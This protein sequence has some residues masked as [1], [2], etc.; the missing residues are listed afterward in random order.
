MPVLTIPDNR[1]WLDRARDDGTLRNHITSLSDDEANAFPYLWEAWARPNQLIPAGMG[2]RFRVWL[3]RAGRG[4]GKTRSGAEAVRRMVDSGQARRIALVAPTVA[5]VRDV[6]IEGESGLLSVFPPHQRPVFQP[7]LRRVTFHNGATATTFSA[8][9]PDRLRGPQHDYAWVE[10]PASMVNGP[11][12][13]S[14]LMLGL[15]LG[16]APWVTV[17]GTPKPL[18]WLRELADR[19]DTIETTG[20]TYDNVRY[21][22]PT[23]IE[24]VLGRFEG[25][26]LGRQELH[27]EWLEGVEGALWVAQVIDRGRIPH[28]DREHPWSTINEWRTHNGLEPV[29][30]RRMWRTVVAVDPPGETAECGIV[31]ATA[32]TK[33]RAGRDPVVILADC[34]VSGRPEQWGAAVV[35]AYRTWG[36]QSVVVEANQG[37]DMTRST[38]HAVSTDVPVRKIH[39]RDSKQARAEPVSAL[40]ERGLV[41]HVGYHPMLESQMLSWVPDESRSPDRLDAMVH[42]VRSLLETSAAGSKAR[43][44]SPAGRRLNR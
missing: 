40:Y 22:A 41:H 38:V 31:V 35:A 32:P 27:A 7:S 15:R 6:M 26:R 30:D 8:E 37:G 14:N 10:E 16:A 5:D 3:F 24:D 36:A 42:A 39:A 2:E 4:S 18:T 12:V 20:S 25:T 21:L 17:T 28:F 13:M 19:P 23:F 29:R 34:S 33:G 43:V 1:S 44:S 11:E 9:K